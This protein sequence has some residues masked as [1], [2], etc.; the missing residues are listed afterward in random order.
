MD[1]YTVNLTAARPTA[2]FKRCSGVL[3]LSTA[4]TMLLAGPAQA[5]DRG[6]DIAIGVA[7]GTVLGIVAARAADTDAT[8][9]QAPV[10]VAPQYASVPVYYAPQPVY[11]SPP[12]YYAYPVAP[13]P[14]YR[15]RYYHYRR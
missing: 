10:Y 2:F 7:V 4:C 8:V 11:Y 14:L 13:M 15:G 1:T 12:V 6:S 3:V 5:R 9:Y